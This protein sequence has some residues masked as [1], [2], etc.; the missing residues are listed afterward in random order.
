MPQ[1]ASPPSQES[2]I[3]MDPRNPL[4][5]DPFIIEKNWLRWIFESLIPKL[6][7]T[8]ETVL[9]PASSGGTL[10]DQHTSLAPTPLAVGQL[11][12]GTY[13]ITY[14]ARVTTID[15]VS[16]SLTVTLGWTEDALAL[17]L[18]GPAMAADSISA[19]QSGSI[20]VTIDQNSALTIA[21][22]YAS[23]TPNQMRYKLE[24]L[25]EQL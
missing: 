5:K 6:Q 24:F 10:T 3:E 2:L 23:N 15:G 19:P 1:I 14:Y 9:T 22:T 13:R 20:M 25:I 8:G 4:R 12:A 18:S 7:S 11:S 16:S 21:T 17:S